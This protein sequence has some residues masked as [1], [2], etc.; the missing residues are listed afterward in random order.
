MLPCCCPDCGC[1][2]EQGSVPACE[3]HLWRAHGHSKAGA[4]LLLKMCVET[5]DQTLEAGEHFKDVT[6]WLYAQSTQNLPAKE[7]SVC[8]SKEPEVPGLG[9][10][11]DRDH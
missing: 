1:D 6:L 3:S 11:T 8:H 9:I 5:T 10:V 2:P 4:D 7:A